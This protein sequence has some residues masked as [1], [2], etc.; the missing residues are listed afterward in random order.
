MVNLIELE[1]RF[2][3]L[4]E[5]IQH[6][7]PSHLK[8]I[9]T[10]WRRGRPVDLPI[11]DLEPFLLKVHE[12]ENF[13]DKMIFKLR[14]DYWM[15][16]YALVGRHGDAKTQIGIFLKNRIERE[17]ETFC[18]FIK[19]DF[20][21]LNE[22]NQPVNLFT[23]SIKKF[24]STDY[25]NCVIIIDEIDA[26]IWKGEEKYI[27][28]IAKL[29][30][31]AIT[32]TDKERDDGKRI[33]V[34]FL[35]T[36]PNFKFITTLRDMKDRLRRLTR[37]EVP[38]VI[39]SLD[40]VVQVALVSLSILHALKI[41]ETV[42]NLNLR[43][44]LSYAKVLCERCWNSY[45]TVGAI[46]GAVHSKLSYFVNN[47][48]EEGA[49]PNGTKLGN[50]IE[51][52]LR[53]YITITRPIIRS[54]LIIKKDELFVIE[55]Y[56]AT[57]STER[58]RIDNRIS[59]G[60]CLIY[61]GETPSH[62]PLF[63][64][65][66]EIKAG[67]YLINNPDVE[68]KL[69][70]FSKEY[71][72]LLIAAHSDVESLEDWGREIS[73]K[74]VSSGG[75]PIELVS[76]SLNELKYAFLLK[77]DERINYVNNLFPIDDLASH[78]RNIIIYKTSIKLIEEKGGMP[79]EKLIETTNLWCKTFLKKDGTLKVRI[80]LRSLVNE[81]RKLL[82]PMIVKL[83]VIINYEEVVDET[84]N[85]L[86]KERILVRDGKWIRPQPNTWNIERVKDVVSD[87]ILT[88]LRKSGIEI[89]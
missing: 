13:L 63:K 5:K 61:S 31:S 19:L 24:M 84:I 36:D 54:P 7:P 74:S 26:Y 4:T 88:I 83:G 42:F 50:S 29:I 21:P 82:E 85:R 49:I 59:D 23:N 48:D 55:P 40:D 86:E 60:L 51:T 46:V 70:T 52:L 45:G 81:F 32:Y 1:R 8:K 77:E 47:F 56:C 18:E 78:L 39:T 22:S 43:E 68:E 65:P 87:A 58:I 25:K 80:G 20:P 64:I 62:T 2:R 34:V 27:D 66:L 12:I 37:V 53:Q 11:S 9:D 10:M 14:K 35:M 89:L 28:S 41:H 67:D 38:H 79:K 69:F 57:F 30:T 16:M 17:P 76:L 73:I 3:E 6:R 72:T 75:K 44:L 33:S 15:G 71:P